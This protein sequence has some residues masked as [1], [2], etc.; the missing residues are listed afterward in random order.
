[1]SSYILVLNPGSSTLKFSLYQK[2][3]QISRRSDIPLTAS[4]ILDR[5]GTANA[6]LKINIKSGKILDIG[7]IGGSISKSVE[8]I[9]DAL[10]AEFIPVGEDSFPLSVI[11]CRVVHGGSRFIQ[12]T[13]VDQE[14]LD[15]IQ[16]L[17][18]LAPLH[19]PVA[20]DVLKAVM[21]LMPEVPVVAV[22][23]TAFHHTLPAVS[24]TYA[25]PHELCEQNNLYKFGFHGIAHHYVSHKLIELI[26]K[27]NSQSKCITCHLGSGASICAVKN[28]VSIDTTMGMTPLEGLAMATRCGDVDPGLL[29]Y[30]LRE[31]QISSEALDSLLNHGSG[32]L[33][34]SG[35]SGDVR[36][37]EAAASGGDERAE[38][39]LEIF[40]YRAS[41]TIG[42]YAAALEG[43]D[44]VA[45]SGGIGEH[46]NSMRQRICRR[47][48]FL[49][50]ELLQE[51]PDSDS[52]EYQISSPQS[53]VNVWVIAA[54]EEL[55]IAHETLELL[56][57]KTN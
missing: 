17:A 22:F 15:T 36:D 9:L 42:A 31:K 54:N 55:Q 49:G 11:C 52:E 46:S 26:G 32:L 21:N 23:D 5:L 38:L 33:G 28:G 24:R 20:A 53:R 19:N 13:R 4:G 29:L 57:S 45:F 12:P 25:L 37:L 35:K 41:K 1:M 48:A 51:I 3:D 56:K 50:I 14:V 6:A 34:I 18:P 44:A 47:L 30:L 43:L 39:A 10:K 8:T 40:A 27:S 2:P 16:S 7:N